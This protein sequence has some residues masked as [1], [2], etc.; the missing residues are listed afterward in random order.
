MQKNT[1]FKSS[2]SSRSV[3]MAIA[4]LGIAFA[5]AVHAKPKSEAPAGRNTEKIIL[6][7]PT[8]LPE[9]ARQGGE[10]MLLHETGDG[11]TLLYIEQHEGAQLAIFDVSDPS[12]IKALATVQLNTQGAFDFVAPLGDRAELVR[13]R[14]GQGAAVL[15]L[16]KVKASTIKTVEALE[17]QSREERLGDDGLIIARQANVRS[18]QDLQIVETANSPDLNRSFGVKGVHEELTNEETGT[19][20]L[21]ADDGLYIVRRPAIEEEYQIHQIQLNFPG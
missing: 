11:R 7:R 6:V 3:T 19:T 4:A 2:V 16:H 8:D 18:A 15:D 1:N 13:F 9:L 10:A 17:L 12:K 14:Q 20:F 21:L 5:P